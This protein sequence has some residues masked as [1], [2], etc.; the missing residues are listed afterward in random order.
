MGMDGGG[1]H[2]VNISE[3]NARDTE[4]DAAELALGEKN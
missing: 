3:W 4:R 2:I 1:V